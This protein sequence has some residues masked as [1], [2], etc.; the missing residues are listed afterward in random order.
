MAV[1]A[2]S[3]MPGRSNRADIT[4]GAILLV[5][6]CL[7]SACNPSNAAP[8]PRATRSA[9]SATL[10]PSATVEIL[11]S[12]QLYANETP[13]GANNLVSANL[14]SGQYQ[15][16]IAL[17]TSSLAGVQPIEMVLAD[18]TRLM[19]SLY[20]VESL[21]RVPGVLLLAADQ[22][23][24]GTLPDRL[25]NRGYSVVVVALPR[26]DYPVG[27]FQSLLETISLV[28]SIDPAYI[29]VLAELDAANWALEGCAAVLLCDAL[30]I[31]SPTSRD[32]TQA[33]IA[34]Y[35]PRPLL[36]AVA[37]DDAANYSVALTLAGAAQTST[38]FVELPTGSGAELLLLDEALE[39][40]LMSFLEANLRPV[41][42]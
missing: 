34:G 40:S 36:I 17:G 39:F 5:W 23:Q 15:P 19:A 27:D 30:A 21:T 42:N 7:L 35:A 9:S 31:F 25:R 32:R 20:E 33:A 37:V 26:A 14:P 4:R 29:A 24:W 1:S 18:G 8:T 41:E 2:W 3:S 11:S 16:P 22:Q 10:Q 6:V 13:S 12:D 38:V 28:D